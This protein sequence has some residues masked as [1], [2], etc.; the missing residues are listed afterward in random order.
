MIQQ[1]TAAPRAAMHP[2]GYAGM[3]ARRPDLPTAGVERRAQSGH[4][5][6]AKCSASSL[7]SQPKKL[8]DSPKPHRI[9]VVDDDTG[10]RESLCALLK[11]RGYAEPA[12]CTNGQ[13]LLEMLME[14]PCDLVLLDLLM[15]KVSGLDVLGMLRQANLDVAVVVVSGDSMIESAISAM[16]LG[17]NDYVRKPYTAEML[18]FSIETVLRRRDL[19]KSHRQM[20]DAL[21]QSERQYRFLVEA[22]PDLIFTLDEHF[23][24]SF[25]S[26]HVASLNGYLA[27]DLKGK[28]FLSIVFEED[29]ERTRY[30]LERVGHG[31]CSTELRFVGRDESAY[32]HYDVSLIPI[33]A[34]AAK[35]FLGNARSCRIYGVARDISD[36]ILNHDRLAF[37]AYH[38]ALTGLPNRALFC[39][40]VG[41]AMVQAKRSGMKIAAMFIDLDRFKLAN[42]NFGHQ[43]GDELLKDVARRLQESLRE[44]DTLARIGGDEFTVLLPGLRTREDAA[45]VANKL[46]A[47]MRKPF[48]LADVEV[49][50]TASIGISIFPDDG[51]DIETLLRHADIAMYHVKS[52][53]KNGSGFFSNAMDEATSRRVSIES[54]IRHGL[55]VGEFELHYQPQVDAATRHIVGLEALSRWQH[56]ASGLLLAGSFIPAIEEI[57][58]MPAFTYQVLETACRDLR[59]GCELGYDMPRMSVKV[60]PRVIEQD[61]FLEHLLGLLHQYAVPHESFEIEITENVFIGDRQKVS[62]RLLQI[63]RE[64][65]RI[66]IDDFGTQYASL[67]YLRYLPVN[68][69]KIEQSLIRE[70]ERSDDKSPI[71]RAIVA[72]ALGL[73]LDVV[74]EGVETEVQAGYLHQLG[75]RSMQGY[76]FGQPMGFEDIAPLLSRRAI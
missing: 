20:T 47:D 8:V 63:S 56:P 11:S 54:E 19:E 15:P 31:A 58:L 55:E 60:S 64:G 75:C 67:S 26:G 17:A 28:P 35:V 6:I 49:T 21:A 66:A 73:G 52:H 24:F 12:T 72:V 37:L 43:K 57:G 3:L 65:I 27:D 32:R 9:V 29:L 38:D 1:H 69:L 34:S 76:L 5:G 70:I 4:G 33:E 61:D 48:L 2:V 14:S 44:T 13:E 51:E 71:V 36:K 16:R 7:A 41:L 68:T 50:L 23:N 45:Y 53:G 10:F 22:S 40:R 46:V 39:D 30:T 25:I 74:A 62:D 42:D 18:L 59:H